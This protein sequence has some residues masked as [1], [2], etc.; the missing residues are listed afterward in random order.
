MRGSTIPT[1]RWGRPSGWQGCHSRTGAASLDYRMGT[2]W[3]TLAFP[4]I[5]Y[6]PGQEI[7]VSLEGHYQPIYG[8]EPESIPSVEG[9]RDTQRSPG[10]A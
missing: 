6:F 2:S 4:D 10:V 7:P 8:P 5:P 3:T 9:D 1:Y